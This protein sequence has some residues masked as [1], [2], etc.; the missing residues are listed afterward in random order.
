MEENA[1][2]HSWQCNNGFVQFGATNG[3]MGSRSLPVIVSL[4]ELMAVCEPNFIAQIGN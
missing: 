3:R 2:I 1:T 4:A